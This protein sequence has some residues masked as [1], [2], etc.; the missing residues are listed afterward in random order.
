M[1]KISH[2]SCVKRWDGERPIFIPIASAHELAENETVFT[3]PFM[4]AIN[5]ENNSCIATPQGEMRRS[6]LSLARASRAKICRPDF[7]ARAGKDKRRSGPAKVIEF[8][9]T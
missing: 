9:R 4:L 7:A 5:I 1:S 3:G 6:K 2:N 8:R